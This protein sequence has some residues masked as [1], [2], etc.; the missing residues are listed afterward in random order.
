VTSLRGDAEADAGLGGDMILLILALA[1]LAGCS[2]TNANY[3]TRPF[4]QP[5]Q[6]VEQHGRKTWLDHL[7]ETDPGTVEINVAADYEANSPE[8]IA[9]LPFVDHGSG[10]FRVDKIALTH[11]GKRLQEAW[12]WTYAN[13]LRRSLAGQMAQRE[14]TIVPMPQ[15]DMV[16]H[17]RG[18]DTWK[19]LMAVPPQQLGRWLDADTVV[20]GEVLQHDAYYAFLMAAWDVGVKV[21]LISTF[22]GRQLFEATDNRYAVDWRPAFGIMDVGLNSA[23]SLLELRD[24]T[25]ARAEDEVSREIALRVPV[26]NRAVEELQFVSRMSGGVASNAVDSPASDRARASVR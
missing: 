6:D 3:E 7:I 19:K 22:N 2:A 17:D 24:V 4:F 11:R 1:L 8:R 16:L 26:S 13:R 5:E 9:V 18:I 15:I 14:F 20:Y 21:Q 12:A 23:L 25:L 10:Q